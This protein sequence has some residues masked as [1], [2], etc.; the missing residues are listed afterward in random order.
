MGK[1]QRRALQRFQASRLS[2]IHEE[3][4][5]KVSFKDNGKGIKKE[6]LDKIFEPYFTTKQNGTGLGLAISKKLIQDMKGIIVIKS[7]EG[8]GTEVIISFKEIGGEDNV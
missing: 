8:I 2:Y 4:Y 5:V 6:E 1:V 3:G 7:S